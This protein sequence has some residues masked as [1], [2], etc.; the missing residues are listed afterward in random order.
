LIYCFEKG[1]T[2]LNWVVVAAKN[3]IRG[4]YNQHGS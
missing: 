2:I 1:T 4:Y 3:E